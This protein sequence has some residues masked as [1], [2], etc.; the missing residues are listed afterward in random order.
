MHE[1]AEALGR[2]E[3]DPYWFPGGQVI[4]I[5]LDGTT[6]G[7][8]FTLLE[9]TTDAGGGAPQAHVH[10]LE[11][12][13]LFLL[14]GRVEVTIGLEWREVLPGDVIFFPRDVPH[15]FTNPGPGRSRGIGVIAPAGLEAFFRELGTPKRGDER[16]LDLREPG[17]DEWEAAAE[18]AGMRLLR[19]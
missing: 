16:P 7:G 3:R 19:S 18:R 11:D 4:D 2:G 17:P 9:V 15:T 8:A 5:K 1:P 14:E 10:T 6:T 13:T 12:E